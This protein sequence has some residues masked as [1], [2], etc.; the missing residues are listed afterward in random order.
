MPLTKPS[1]EPHSSPYVIDCKTKIHG[2]SIQRNG[3]R[4]DLGRSSDQVV[5]EKG[6]GHWLGIGGSEQ[7][8]ILA[9]SVPVHCE[10]IPLSAYSGYLESCCRS[11]PIGCC[12][13]SPGFCQY[14]RGLKF[15]RQD[16][17]ESE[18]VMWI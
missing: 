7:L 8:A 18:E 17:S 4:V 16:T 12:V 11:M 2:E 14:N 10:F 1:I 5:E 6:I 3:L 13:I 9:N 15:G